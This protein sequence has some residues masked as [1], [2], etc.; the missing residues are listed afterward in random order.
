MSQKKHWLQ[1]VTIISLALLSSLLPNAARAANVWYVTTTGNDGN[2]CDSP[3]TACLTVNAA[4]HKAGFLNGDTVNVASGTY[5]DTGTQ[6]VLLD[7]SATLS[8]GW[9]TTFSAQA[10]ISV[11]DGQGSFASS[12]R[13]R[14]RLRR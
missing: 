9:E 6:V 1:L 14:E 7:K 2:P 4:L 13:I 5:T 10:G 8:G 12:R 11:L 3:A